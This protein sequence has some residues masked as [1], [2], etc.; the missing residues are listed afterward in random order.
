[1]RSTT[2]QLYSGKE[3]KRGR[4][5][6]Q[7]EIPEDVGEPVEDAESEKWALVVRK[8]RVYGDPKKTLA[9]HSVLVQSPLLK[10]LL[11]NVLSD[12]PGV[13][14][15]LKRLEF[16]GRFEPL[17][18]RWPQLKS[19]VGELRQKQQEGDTDV[20]L[21]ERIMHAEL[22]D[23][24][25]TKEFADIHEAVGD[26]T[27]NGVTT[28]EHLWVL[29]QPGAIVYSKQ[30]NQDR[31]LL[32]QSSKYGVDRNQQKVLWLTCRYVDFDGT[33]FGTQKLN[34]SIA[35]FDGVCPIDSLA[36][37]P[38]EHHSSA[39]KL[40]AKLMERGGK[41]EELAGSHY[42][43][44]NG[45]G[46]KLNSMAQKEPTTVKGRI[47]VDTFGFNRF[48]PDQAIY[49]T[50]LHARENPAAAPAS[51]SSMPA[52]GMA[53]TFIRVTR[54]LENTGRLPVNINDYDDGGMPADGFFDHEAESKTRAPLS[55][56]HKIL[57][58]PLVR[59]YALREKVWL[60]FF[61]NSV[62]DITFSEKAFEALVLPA[63]QKELLLGFSKTNQSE[64]NQFD[65]VIAGKGKGI[66]VLLCGPP[67]V[68]QTLTAESVAEEMRV[69][70]YMM[71]AGD[72]GLDSRTI[73][74]K[75]QGVLDMCTRWK[76]VLLI[77]EAD[78][79]LEQRD[80]HNLER[81]KLVSI[82][83]RVLEYYEGTMFLTTNRVQT[84]DPAFQSRIHISLE[85]A[86]LDTKARRSIWKTFLDQHNDRATG[87]VVDG[88]AAERGGRGALA[89]TMSESDMRR[90]SQLELNGRQIKNVLKVA[91]MLAALHDQALGYGHVEAAM[92]GTQYLY[93]ATQASDQTK[94]SLFGCDSPSA[95]GCVASVGG[96]GWDS[97][98]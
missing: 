57:C 71:S 9:M 2:Q 15:T 30:D 59:G 77:D 29:F 87:A 17:I 34:L 68:G 53:N 55:E 42:R 35:E 49:L 44:Y 60:N 88:F 14:V 3:D 38:I 64:D 61:V 79:F 83:L 19:A 22:L 45:V 86:E 26:M 21:G 75:L 12:Y 6:W 84:F 50:P 8:V 39:E 70:L 96:V 82:F 72:L 81:N 43:N 36:A 5:Q 24:L 4:F 73:E 62:Q 52:A 94:S 85:Y 25:L 48:N 23:S 58:I 89:H 80:L 13:T 31:A 40:K 98:A 74:M 63:N 51:G 67:G 90:L 11:E 78:V 91:A 92:E 97:I 47:V 69:P 56:E 76:A 28:Y 7:T 32:L 66:I 20:C 10:E 65:D 33:S 41:I 46:W 93:K 18:H 95:T 1:M 16:S 27:K 54:S 37:F